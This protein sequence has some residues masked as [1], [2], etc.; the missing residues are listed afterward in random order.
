MCLPACT[1][2]LADKASRRSF[3]RSMG[4]AA[5]GAAIAPAAIRADEIPRFSFQRV[6]DLTH[7]LHAQFPFPIDHAFSLDR[8]ST[9]PNE[10]WNVYRWP[11]HEHIGTHID[12]P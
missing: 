10:M 1:I 6:V 5:A 7:T 12:A 9:R 3:L 2:Q 4:I 8:I 11:F